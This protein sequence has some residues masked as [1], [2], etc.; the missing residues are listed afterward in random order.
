MINH[1]LHASHTCFACDHNFP[2]TGDVF[3]N[4]IITHGNEVDATISVSAQQGDYVECAVQLQCPECG[5]V[6]QFKVLHHR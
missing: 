2:W 6:N 1:E 4:V 3:G 5:A